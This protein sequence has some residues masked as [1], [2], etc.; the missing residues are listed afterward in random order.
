M[1]PVALAEEPVDT[2]TSPE[3]LEELEPVCSCNAPLED[4]F[5]KPVLIAMEPLLLTED[6]VAK[7][8]DP[9]EP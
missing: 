2:V 8:R 9:E 3:G 5:E 4:E 1:E 6:G 7:L